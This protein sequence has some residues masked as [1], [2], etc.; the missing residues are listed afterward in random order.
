L[1]KFFS[2]AVKVKEELFSQQ[3][4]SRPKHKKAPKEKPK[5]KTKKEISLSG[6]D[7]PQNKA[8]SSKSESI[9][10]NPKHPSGSRKSSKSDSRQDKSKSQSATSSS[11]SDRIR[12]SESSSSISK[13]FPKVKVFRLDVPTNTVSKCIGAKLGPTDKDLTWR[14]EA[15]EKNPPS[16]A[17]SSKKGVKHRREGSTSSETSSQ[18]VKKR[19]KFAIESD[20]EDDD[21]SDKS[22]SLLQS[23]PEKSEL[24]PKASDLGSVQKEIPKDLV[25]EPVRQVPEAEQIIFSDDE[26]KH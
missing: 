11:K 5:S 18:K 20:S 15:D 21:A 24:P 14:F 8:A 2:E 13:R 9:H 16:K 4:T 25:S 19:R 23:N 22:V 10:E 1:I 7:K 3:S 12:K 6:N 26:V 17:A